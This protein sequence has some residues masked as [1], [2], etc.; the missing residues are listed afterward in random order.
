M[1]PSGFSSFLT[2]MASL[3]GGERW[4]LGLAIRAPDGPGVAPRLSLESTQ[5]Q[6]IREGMPWRCRE[7]R[8]E[9]ELFPL[10]ACTLSGRWG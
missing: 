4:V 10:P 6:A 5:R 3:N 9:Q 8:R 7:E 2:D 1:T